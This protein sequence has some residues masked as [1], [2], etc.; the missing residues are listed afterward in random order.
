[1]LKSLTL[2]L[3]D[4]TSEVTSSFFPPIEFTGAPEVAL[5]GFYGCNSIPNIDKSNN[6][7]TLINTNNELLENNIEI[8]VPEG[9]YELEDISKYLEERLQSYKISFML[10]ANKNTLKSELKCSRQI[11]FSVE[12]SIGGILGFHR[13]ILDANKIH[14]S[15]QV[16]NINNLTSIKINCNAAYGAF[17]NGIPSH[18]VHEFNPGVAAGYRIVENPK[19]LIYYPLISNQLYSITVKITDQDDKAINFRGEPVTIRL[20]IRDGSSIQ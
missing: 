2:T 9:T 18:T 19:N 15:D 6:T 11:D 5:L 4:T 7:F 14:I 16:A 8:K 3:H 17:D 13:K 10:K 20:H 1:M 12:N